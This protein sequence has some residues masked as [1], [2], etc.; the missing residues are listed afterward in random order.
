M[1]ERNDGSKIANLTQV[2]L[3]EQ[4]NTLVPEG[5]YSDGQSE[6]LRRPDIITIPDQSEIDRLAHVNNQ[7]TMG[8]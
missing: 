8:D 3:R 5:V 2:R 4:G 1:A 7:P 6:I